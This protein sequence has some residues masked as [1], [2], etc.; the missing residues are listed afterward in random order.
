MHGLK[1]PL[2]S[3][4]TRTEGGADMGNFRELVPEMAIEY[5]FELDNFQKEAIVRRCLLLSAAH[6]RRWFVRSESVVSVVQRV[7]VCVPL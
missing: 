7:F 4:R 3:A 2:N 5:P 6:C 1:W